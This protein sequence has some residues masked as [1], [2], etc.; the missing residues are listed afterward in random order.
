MSI[1][2]ELKTFPRY[3]E[4]IIRYL[5]A[6]EKHAAFDA[7][8]LAA[9]EV[10]ERGFRKALRRLVTKE[11]VEMQF[12]GT[13]ALTDTGLEAAE[14]IGPADAPEPPPPDAP[15]APVP[16]PAAPEPTPRSLIVIFPRVLAADQPA[17]CFL[18]VDAPEQPI[19]ADPIGITARI[20]SECRTLPVLQQ[21]VVPVDG[22]SQPIRFEV[23]APAAGEFRA[24]LEVFKVTDSDLVEA[25]KFTLAFHA[26]AVP[27]ASDTFEM[28][29]F[30]LAL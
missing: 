24:T 10:S 21:G 19:L 22:P 27:A 18:R 23:T 5:A 16:E 1:S 30:D 28:Q 8:I 26:E 15:P 29:T 25:G 6:Q 17:Y 13:Y 14:I 7:D 11:Y 9:L 20:Q 4:D 2:H 12:E 3:S